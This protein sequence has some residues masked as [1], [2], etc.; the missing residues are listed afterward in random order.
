V[1]L[2]RGP[3]NLVRIME[4]LLERKVAAAVYKT[5][6]PLKLSLISLTSGGS[7]VG[8]VRWRTSAPEFF[9]INVLFQL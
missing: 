1:D 9:I 6:Y 7:S 5:L 8:I 4:E 3:L 2:E